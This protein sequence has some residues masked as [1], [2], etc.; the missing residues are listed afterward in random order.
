MNN[1][2]FFIT[3]SRAEFDLT[4]NL[5]VLLDK[6]K[7]V[8]LHLV[9]TATHLSKKYGFTYNYIK[10]FKFKNQ[11]IV[12]THIEKKNNDHNLDSISLGIN[13]ISKLLVRHKPNLV[14]VVGD[15]YEMLYCALSSYFLNIPIV[16]FFGGEVTYGS[17]DDGIRHSLSK[18]SNFHFVTH[19]NHRKRL[20]QLGEDKKNIFLTSHIG[21]DSIL[22][23]KFYAKEEI[24][25]LLNIDQKK[26]NV[27]IVFHPENTTP[28]KIRYQALLI[29]KAMSNLKSYNLIFN[30]P[31]SD[32]NSNIIDSVFKNFVKKNKNSYYI[33][34]LGHQK[35]LSLLN[36]AKFII[37]NSSSGL[38]EMPFF[39]KPTINLGKRQEG[40]S[41][42]DT[43]LN[44]NFNLK[45]IEKAIK[46]SLSSN[47]MNKINKDKTY[48]SYQKGGSYEVYKILKRILNK[49]Y[50]NNFINK[51][52][53]DLKF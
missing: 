23:T 27:L 20:I 19:K 50:K 11:H 32:N 7:K 18:L 26:E 43:I 9:I 47:F 3:G 42:G 38:S 24:S 51:K 21:F 13:K 41:G 29:C 6:S 25:K 39:S 44:C 28:Q 4:K 37:G 31:N 52:F 33:D 40:R 5:L 36:S 1:K 49:S 22:N 53:I 8:D 30:K 46:K 2:L 34:N 10:K 16:H 48:Y 17:L 45:N 14:C 15:R 12:K 35:Y